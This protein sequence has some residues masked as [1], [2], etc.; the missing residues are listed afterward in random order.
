[1]GPERASDVPRA[2][3]P[4]TELNSARVQLH[5]LHN[6]GQPMALSAIRSWE[7]EQGGAPCKQAVLLCF[8]ELC[9]TR[10]SLT[11]VALCIPQAGLCSGRRPQLCQAC[12]PPGHRLQPERPLGGQLE[13]V[14]ARKAY[15]WNSF[16]SCWGS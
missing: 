11:R 2:T 4:R 5:L 12:W 7:A 3:Q 10:V 9:P 8:L 1:M 14:L 15:F 13:R 16:L 6:W